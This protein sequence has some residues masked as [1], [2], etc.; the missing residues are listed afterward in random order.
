VP[1]QQIE[2]LHPLCAEELPG[3]GFVAGAE[4]GQVGNAD[5]GPEAVGI[6]ALVRCAVAVAPLQTVVARK[7]ANR[8]LP[9]EEIAARDAL[10]FV[11]ALDA[12]AARGRQVGQQRAPAIA[13]VEAEGAMRIMVGAGSDAP[14][15]LRQI[16]DPDA[17]CGR[18]ILDG[19]PH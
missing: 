4:G 6:D 3:A 17:H 1:K 7:R 15:V 13:F 12:R 8:S 18:T 16:V 14:Y 2:H 5:R 10:Q 9:L 11:A 19:A